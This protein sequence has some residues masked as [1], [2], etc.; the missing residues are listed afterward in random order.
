MLSLKNTSLVAFAAIVAI[1]LVVFWAW[2]ESS[3]ISSRTDE[4]GKRNLALGRSVGITIDFYHAEI[5]KALDHAIEDV[6][7]GRDPARANL[8]FCYIAWVD[9]ETGR[10]KRKI[11]LRTELVADTLS[12]A[13]L[14]DLKTS[15]DPG[16]TGAA[17]LHLQFGRDPELRLTRAK[18][19]TIIVAN[20]A[21]GYVRAMAQRINLDRRVAVTILDPKGRVI[22]SQNQSW[23]RQAKDLSTLELVQKLK[24]GEADS[25]EIVMPE[26]GE[27]VIASA[28]PA[29]GTGWGV[30]FHEP[31][32]NFAGN[33]AAS[34]T[35]AL[36]L[37]AVC[38]LIAALIGSLAAAPIV[39]PLMNVI[40]AARRMQSGG[41]EVR[42]PALSRFAPTELV[43]L[44]QAFNAMAE[45]VMSARAQEADARAKAERASQSKS[46]FLRNVT[47][48]VR[49]PLNAIIG[50]SE[51]LLNECRRMNLPHHQIAHAE[52][53]RAAGQ[54]MLSLV[55]SLLDLSRIEAGQYVLHEAPVALDE[56]V[57]RCIRFLEPAARARRTR[58][59]M[60]IDDT[61]PDVVADE[62]A[63]FQSVLNLT[64][65]AVRYGREGGHVLITDKSARLHGVEI[66]I[67]DDGPGIASEHLDK[68][69]EPFV[70]I[71]GEANRHVEGSG[72]GLPIVKKLVELHGGSFVLE[73]TVGAGTTAR[74]RLPASRLL[75]RSEAAA[76][77]QAAA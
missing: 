46:E 14:A 6:D 64:A 38:I 44:S 4:A 72:L 17:Q 7:A 58:L 52:D 48:E 32:S 15:L 34:Q 2:P 29:A 23:E 22:A 51:V 62:Q 43:E 70:R 26:T 73:S 28:V 13:E 71:A 67:A 3:A 9:S 42:I 25:A 77:P 39:A 8:A 75:P 19:G 76:Q 11:G 31:I 20:I 10:V 36:M 30:I 56:V 40:R 54:H 66:V 74:I 37:T 35:P 60:R 69:M 27:R 68:V 33:V 21:T 63:L 18:P 65:N 16:N 53:I 61:T 49:T 24:S 12:P 50:F 41:A 55:N 45:S 1:P 47:H 59:E 57:S 5:A